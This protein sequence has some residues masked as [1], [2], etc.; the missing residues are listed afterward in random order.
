M[1]M[2]GWSIR[3]DPKLILVRP[4]PWSSLDQLGCSMRVVLNSPWPSLDDGLDIKAD[5][6]DQPSLAQ[7]S[8]RRKTARLQ[9]PGSEDFNVTYVPR[10]PVF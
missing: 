6:D 4:N 7:G 9:K 10:Q 1:I 8:F 2:Q 3:S 5:L